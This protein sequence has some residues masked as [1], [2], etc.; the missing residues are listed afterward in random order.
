MP[1]EQVL[2]AA[3]RELLEETGLKA[4]HFS[5]AGFT[6]NEFSGMTS[7]SLYVVAEYI[8][9]DAEV[10]EPEKCA[11]WQWYDY[12]S[13]PEPLF[14]PVKRVLAQNNDLKQWSKCRGIPVNVHI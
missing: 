4:A 5:Y 13:L 7:I 14:L 12:R 2:Q 3:E 11:C 8:G 10:K 1:G 6:E 9:G